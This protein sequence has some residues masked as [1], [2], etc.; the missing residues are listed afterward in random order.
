MVNSSNSNS[1]QSVNRQRLSDLLDNR[2]DSSDFDKLLEHADSKEVWYRYQTAS[3]VLRNEHSTHTTLSFCQEIS[4]KLAGEPAIIATSI[5]TPA[6]EKPSQSLNSRQKTANQKV[7]T[8]SPIRRFSGGLAI[9]AS[10]AFATFF[11]VQTLQLSD[12]SQPDSSMQQAAAGG[13]GNRSTAKVSAEISGSLEQTQLEFSS[14]LYKL[15]ILRSGQVSQQQ[16]S[17]AYVETV[18]LSAEEWQNLLKRSAKRKADRDV[19]Q[20]NRAP[21][22][23]AKPSN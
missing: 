20:P 10:A 17:D 18:R 13:A 21:D 2:C 23:R 8:V 3:S 7:A 6:K 16:V 11:S 14:D 22:A 9:A 12:S 5:T 15:G 19:S 1:N 4:A